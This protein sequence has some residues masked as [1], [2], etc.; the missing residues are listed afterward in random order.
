MVELTESYTTSQSMD[1]LCT[2]ADRRVANQRARGAR[3]GTRVITKAPL[4]GIM[5]RGARWAMTDRLHRTRGCP[6]GPATSRRTWVDAVFDHLGGPGSKR[7]LDLHWKG[8]TYS[9]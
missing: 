5:K 6:T 3:R 8:G 7:S 9:P 4:H 2:E 1:A